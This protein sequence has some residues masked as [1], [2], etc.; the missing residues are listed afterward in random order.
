[1]EPDAYVQSTASDVVDPLK[2]GMALVD[3]I[4]RTKLVPSK[5][6]EWDEVRGFLSILALVPGCPYRLR[7]GRRKSAIVEFH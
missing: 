5:S 1:M 6:E 2:P 3:L 7:V 4:G